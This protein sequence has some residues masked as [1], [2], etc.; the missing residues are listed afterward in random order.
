MNAKKLSSLFFA[1]IIGLSGCATINFSAHYFTP[2]DNYLQEVTLIWNKILHQFSSKRSYALTVVE[3]ENSKK[4]KGIPAISGTTI[5]LP[6]EFIRYI[7][8]NYYNDR[9]VIVR[10]AIVH[11]L[12]HT[13]Y[14]LVSSPPEKHSETDVAAIR[15]LGG[16]ATQT[17]QQYYK[18]LQVLKSYWF[19]RKGVGG[20]A[21]NVGWNVA[22]AAALALV[23]HGYFVDWFATDIAKRLQLLSRHYK[24]SAGS[25]FR[26]S[27][28]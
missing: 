12:C 14:G 26:R 17:A 18:S 23:G 27:R 7:Y 16:D 2:P 3:G 5:L 25:C 28:Q 9:A 4:L 24:I 20:H 6:D 19:A 8:Q 22:N 11:E 13:E 21:F 1:A 15:V 10:C